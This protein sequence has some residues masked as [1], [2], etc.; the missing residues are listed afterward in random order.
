MGSYP[1]WS[2]VKI[3]YK[4]GAE[5][6]LSYHWFDLLTTALSG[7]ELKTKGLYDTMKM[8]TLGSMQ[9]DHSLKQSLTSA[10]M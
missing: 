10:L 2:F 1:C 5:F 6:L 8:K 9:G 7:L 3:K 4:H